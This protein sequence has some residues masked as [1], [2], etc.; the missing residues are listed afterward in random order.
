MDIWAGVRDVALLSCIRLQ[1]H[2]HQNSAFHW[3][4]Y[5]TLGGS[6]NEERNIKKKLMTIPLNNKCTKRT[7]LGILFIFPSE[8]TSLC[9]LLVFRKPNLIKIIII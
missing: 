5:A 9:W 2:K 8:Y 7:T 4:I 3:M 1:V 6:G